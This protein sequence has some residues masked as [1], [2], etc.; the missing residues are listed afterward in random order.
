MFLEAPPFIN[1]TVATPGK[2]F[3]WMQKI[4]V[5]IF[6]ILRTYWRY[7]SP[8]IWPKIKQMNQDTNSINWFEIPVTDLQRAKHFY[9]LAFSIHMEEMEMNGVTM[10]AF[11]FAPE[12]ATVSGALVKNEQ[13]RPGQDGVLVYLNAE[14]SIQQVLDKAGAEGAEIILP[15]TMISPETGYMA[16]ITDT[17][18]NRIGLHATE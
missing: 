9:Q 7:N 15:K 8:I 13:H 6:F 5:N 17:E 10:A 4:R 12:S 14:P 3:I 18:G 16:I 1:S 2:V 11:P